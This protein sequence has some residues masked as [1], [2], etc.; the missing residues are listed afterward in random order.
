MIGKL[1][2][3]RYQVIQILNQGMFCQTY[4]ARDITISDYPT[5]V[6][7][8]FLPSDRIALPVKIRRR[9]YKREVEALMKL[10]N[11]EYVPHLLNH[12]EYN[13]EFYLVQEFI[14]GHSL[15]TELQPGKRWS[16]TKVIELLQEVLNIL[17]FVHSQGLIHRDVKPSNIMRREGDNKLVLIDF[18]AVKPMW[19][20][21]VKNQSISDSTTIAI[22]TP[23]YMP[24][25]QHQGKP[26][27]SSDIYALGTI[28]IQALTGIH[29][30]QL[31]KDPN[32]G[33]VV[34]R[35]LVRINKKLASVINKMVAYHSQ[36]RYQSATLAFAALMQL[37]KLNCTASSTQENN[38]IL[39]SVE[40]APELN[41]FSSTAT[42]SI[43][44]QKLLAPATNDFDSP[45]LN[46]EMKTASESD[47]IVSMFS[48]KSALYIGLV[49]GVVSGF[50]LLFFSYFSIQT[51][52][53]IKIQNSHI[54][55]L[56]QR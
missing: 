35:H 26:V 51:I 18:G 53:S 10:D 20:E 52:D 49:I 8:H 14:K 41:E 27:P 2:C 9:L 45:T 11:Y 24:Y 43:T 32:T 54:E 25:E 29:P 38:L 19:N 31:P 6:V 33:E 16:E 42:D 1:I 39:A 56:R 5:C 36:N 12:F 3:D 47:T 46:D 21:L 44:L 55:N 37:N 7:K 30:I 28:A 34:W 23:G 13:Q 48:H 4:I 40:L 50:A 17:V 22:G 15:S